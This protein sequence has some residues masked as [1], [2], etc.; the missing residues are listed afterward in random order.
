MEINGAKGLESPSWPGTMLWAVNSFALIVLGLLSEKVTDGETED[1]GASM[2]FPR[3]P[4]LDMQ[5]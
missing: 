5:S 2:A 1:Q 3:S 4:Q